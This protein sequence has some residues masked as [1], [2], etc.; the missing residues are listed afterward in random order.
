MSDEATSKHRRTRRDWPA[1]IAEQRDSTQS[2][3]D[4]CRARGL[5]ETYFYKQRREH[6][7]QGSRSAAP[8]GNDF[9]AL[10]L[11]SSALEVE[12]S[13]GDGVVLRVRRG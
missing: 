5:S 10:P 1:L 4:F 13:L 7:E 2:V 11:P 12:L 6:L 9:I 8:G 3:R